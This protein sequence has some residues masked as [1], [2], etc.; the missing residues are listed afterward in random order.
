MVARL[1]APRQILGILSPTFLLV[2]AFF[3][4]SLAQELYEVIIF[5]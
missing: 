2:S 1:W 5:I 4:I 3:V